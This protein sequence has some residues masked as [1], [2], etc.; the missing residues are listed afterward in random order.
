MRPTSS[1]EKSDGKKLFADSV[2]NADDQIEAFTLLN[3]AETTRS[4]AP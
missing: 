4:R 2:R 1:I 3:S